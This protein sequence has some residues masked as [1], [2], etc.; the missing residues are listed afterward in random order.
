MIFLN[1]LIR[2][3]TGR[4]IG[5]KKGRKGEGGKGSREKGKKELIKEVDW[6]F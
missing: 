5:K 4:K 2:R 3:R 6:A 1:F